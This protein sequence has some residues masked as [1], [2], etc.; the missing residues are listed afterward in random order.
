MC[1]LRTL[2]SSS[3]PPSFSPTC[4]F[5][6]VSQNLSRRRLRPQTESP[7]ESEML[8]HLLHRKLRDLFDVRIVLV[9]VVLL[10]PSCKRTRDRV[11]AQKP[12]PF[13]SCAPTHAGTA[14]TGTR[15]SQSF[16]SSF[17]QAVR[18]VLLC[19]GVCHG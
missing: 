5:A 10:V 9:V 2:S 4:A 16:Q 12:V 8:P 1:A 18:P 11:S 6:G 17:F 13:S 14:A 15:A 7:R 3:L 19:L